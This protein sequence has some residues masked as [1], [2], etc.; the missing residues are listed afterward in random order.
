[1]TAQA[2]LKAIEASGEAALAQLRAEAEERVRDILTEA[3]TAALTRKESARRATLLPLAGERARLLHQANAEAL[4][5]V[6]L[7][8]Q[9]LVEA[10]LTET[11][12]HLARL[13]T[14]SGYACLLRNLV[15]EAMTALGAEEV[16]AHPPI[17]E[18]D[19]R[20]APLLHEILD[21][22][23]L[24]WSIS[25]TLE[26]WGGVIVLSSDGRISVTNTLEARLER[27]LP[28]LRR[29]LGALLDDV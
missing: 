15:V 29:D 11:R 6:G 4:R 22:L 21:Q 18:A 9:Q 19:A 24:E 26:S 17:L 28:L 14:A 23:H 27:A 8:R 12:S 13:R 7:A 5:L 1:M 20:D 16:A 10:V 25:S 2:I 3:E